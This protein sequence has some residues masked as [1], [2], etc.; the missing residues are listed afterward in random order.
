M[1]FGRT[2]PT[3]L[4]PINE[5]TDT[6]TI[7]APNNRAGKIPSI[8]SLNTLTATSYSG[9]DTSVTTVDGVVTLKE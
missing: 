1:P 6:F 9:T 7:F 4:I 2:K 3:Y 8:N 5:D